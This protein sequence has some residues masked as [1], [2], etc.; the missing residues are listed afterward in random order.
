[1]QKA[2]ALLGVIFGKLTRIKRQINFTIRAGGFPSETKKQLKKEVDAVLCELG[3]ITLTLPD[4]P[5]FTESRADADTLKAAAWDM[6]DFIES[7]SDAQA[8][9][10]KQELLKTQIYHPKRAKTCK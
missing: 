8:E 10:G 4:S 3:S 7:A 5:D 6:F 9:Q 2:P 1:M